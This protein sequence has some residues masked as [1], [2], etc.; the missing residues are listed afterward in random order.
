MTPCRKNM[1]YN[2]HTHYFPEGNRDICAI[3][4]VGIHPWYIQKDNIEKEL[5]LIEKYASSPNVRAIGECGLDKLCETD[6]ELQK[7][8]FLSHIS[9]SEKIGKPLIIHCVKSFD[10]I[11]FFKK[12]CRPAQTWIIHGFRGRPQQA[13][14]LVESGFFLS[15]GVNHNEQ[16]IKNIPIERIFFETDDSDCDIRTIYK[17][18]AKILNTSEKNLIRQIEENFNSIFVANF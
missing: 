4:S 6:F 15:F 16:S 3:V 9:I 10:E 18:A 5:D 17:N 2:L 8:V 7:E 12:K 11:M 14:Q 13:K 1:Y